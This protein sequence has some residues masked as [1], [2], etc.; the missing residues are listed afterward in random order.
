MIVIVKKD[1]MQIVGDKIVFDCPLFCELETDNPRHYDEFL[2]KI[3]DDI[4]YAEKM[5]QCIENRTH[6]YST[7]N[8]FEMQYNDS[9]NNTTTWIDA[10]KDIKERY[11]KPMFVDTNTL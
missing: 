1:F 5:R 8:Q 9:M 11:P 7:L 6:A 2:I 10:I 4:I 3:G